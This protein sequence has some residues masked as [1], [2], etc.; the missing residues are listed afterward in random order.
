MKTTLENDILTLRKEGKTYSQ[1]QKELGCSRGTISY[2][3]GKGQKDK[4]RQRNKKV[5]DEN[6][7]SRKVAEFKSRGKARK[8]FVSKTRDF[9]RRDGLYLASTPETVDFTYQ[10]VLDKIGPNPTCYLTGLPIDLSDPSSYHFD[11]IIPASQG[12]NN[13]LENLGIALKSANNAKD[14]LLLGEFLDLC[15][16]VLKH[17]GRI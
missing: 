2:Y 15:E 14:S 11:H 3:V 9:Q 7:V 8:N 6:P 1:I 16:A 4:T 13:S 17:H 5:R 10:D 12:G